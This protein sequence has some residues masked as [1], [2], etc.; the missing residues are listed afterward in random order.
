MT[1]G[2]ILRG[3]RTKY[4][5]YPYCISLKNSPLICIGTRWASMIKFIHF[6][7]TVSIVGIVMID[8]L[9]LGQME[10]TINTCLMMLLV[11]LVHWHLLRL[12]LLTLNWFIGI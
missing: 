6:V 12:M 5:E 2:N 11:L 3:Y 7:F 1:M 9:L 10:L 4:N 8:E